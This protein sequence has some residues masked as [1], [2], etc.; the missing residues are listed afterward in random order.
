MLKN[1]EWSPKN[2]ASTVTC[3][4]GRV[5]RAP[6]WMF[7]ILHGRVSF[8]ES[9]RLGETLLYADILL[10]VFRAACVVGGA[11]VQ[12]ICTKAAITRHCGSRPSANPNT[13]ESPA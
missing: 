13:K 2:V 11:V 7:L 1:D 6:R 8:W 10:G 9:L 4:V 5:I 3:A 12:P